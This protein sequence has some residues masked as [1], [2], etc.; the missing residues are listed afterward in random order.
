MSQ[1]ASLPQSH[2]QAASSLLEYFSVSPPIDPLVLPCHTLVYRLWI[3]PSVEAERDS[4][5]LDFL[6]KDGFP[7]QGRP[8][9][10][11]HV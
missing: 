5:G 7:E 9:D 6:A 3:G 4:P 10:R 8:P 11:E 1:R 2:G